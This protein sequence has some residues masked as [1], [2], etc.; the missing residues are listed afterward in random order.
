MENWELIVLIFKNKFVILGFLILVGLAMLYMFHRKRAGKVFMKSIPEFELPIDR[1]KKIELKNGMNV[2][3]FK[4]DTAPKVI[5]QVAYE[6]GSFVEGS[7]ERGLAHLIEHMIFKGTDK[8]TEGDIDA[9]SRKYGATYNAFTSIDMTSYYFEANKSNWQPFLPILADCMQNARFDE[10]HLASELK[11]VIQE[12]KMYKD[13]YWRRIFEKAIQT[14]F[15]SN[16]PYHFPV[17]GYQ[18]DLLSL[19]AEN[20]KR[21][22]KKYYGPDR[23]TLFI[24]GD[25]DEAQ[26]IE[27]A[28]QN[29]ENIKPN[30]TE[31]LPAMPPVIPQFSSTSVRFYEDVKNNKLCFFWYIPGLRDKNEVL[32]SALDFLLG[33]GEGSRLYRK[34]VEEKKVATSVS[35]TASTMMAGGIFGIFIEPVE[36][37]SDY[38]QALV[39]RELMK[40]MKRG[41]TECELVR[42][43]KNNVRSFF[44]RLQNY[45]DFTYTWI[46]SYFATHD[47]FAV[48]KRVNLYKQVTSKQLQ[49]F[50]RE[51]MDPL[52]MNR[53]EM[54]PL[55]DDKRE[56]REQVQ[57]MSDEIDH[58]ILK[59]HQRVV[60]LEPPKLVST[61][62][63]PNRFDFEF[64]K[65]DV[66]ITLDN[67]LKVLLKK[68][69][70]WGLI[71]LGMKFKDAEYLSSAKDGILVGVMM[72]ILM[73][74]SK[75]YSK[76]Q[77]VDFFESNGVI[78]KFDTSGVS[79]SMLNH[80]Y[81]PVFERLFHILRKPSFSKS[82]LSKLK[83]ISISTFKRC[84]DEPI[85]VLRR[86]ISC[87]VYKNHPYSWTFD[88]AIAI[89]NKVGT[90]E[91]LQL[92]M[93]YVLPAG[94]ILTI[95]GDFDLDEMKTTVQNVFGKWKS[96][97]TKKIE[98]KSGD[99][100][101]KEN[102]DE[103]MMRD[104]V[105]MAFCQTSPLTVYDADIIPVKMLN[106]ITF[107]S[108][109][110]R[111]YQ[112]REQTGLFYNAFGAY[113][114]GAGK[115]HGFD[116][117]G[118]IL[119]LDKLEFAEVGI[120]DLIKD[121]A[122]NGATQR[123]LDD[124]RQ[125]Y[126]KSLIDSV[127]SN[128]DLAGMLNYLESMQLG[129]DYYD[130]VLARV[131]AMSLKEVNDVAAKY[132]STENM[133]RI[134]V[135]RVGQQKM[136]AKS[137]EL[138]LF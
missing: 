29:F 118:A 82:A 51:Y 83:E 23:A 98:Y 117:V 68:N 71:T 130:K 54:V 124:A 91:L 79:I 34:L 66:E 96:D 58:E 2:I 126:L 19:K 46:R 1:V 24:V 60:P 39:T 125:L 111:I 30:G 48:L 47:E 131:Q 10:Q 27:L 50:V 55:P 37:K 107:Y 69:S 77:N 42:M 72:D 25:F 61:L 49:D 88:D 57:R 94:M 78:Y 20:L 9:I 12:V 18:E 89:V 119:S 134:R 7:G 11:A 5:V 63:S 114:A 106:Y 123:E 102:I 8:M 135:G 3:L 16:H 31:A 56:M 80:G 105:L 132:F 103:F 100:T 13:D 136:I 115:M 104:Q 40:I 6:V 76:E 43:V 85:D 35:T 112:L 137:V 62:Q 128:S 17:I 59:H 120:R 36:G 70:S 108:L 22:Y 133:A 99:F 109:G 87:M 138:N 21:F 65:P 113:A 64:P 129:F 41:F 53:I 26:A 84:K 81:K 110:S 14:V 32:S 15:P 92:H 75:K 101:A 90:T 52:F 67:G 73:E 127:S 93:Q 116:Y 74:G 28:K 97:S 122:K 4:T 45:R 121:L 38:C 44:S 95:V 86:K 33:G